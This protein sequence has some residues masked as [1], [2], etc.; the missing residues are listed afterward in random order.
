MRRL[1]ARRAADRAVDVGDLAAAPA[2]HVVV[3]VADPR[4]EPGRA[5]GR[6]DPPGQAGPGQRAEHVVDRL[7]GDRVEPFADPPGDLVDLEV[8]PPA[9]TSSTASRGRVTRRPCERSSSSAPWT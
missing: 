2:D 1:Q 7:G 8:P 9:S 3:V 6:L 4:L 5:A